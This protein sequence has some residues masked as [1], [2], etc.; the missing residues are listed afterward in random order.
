MEQYKRLL[1]YIKPYW[2]IAAIAT[3]FSFATSGISGAMVWYVKP[4]VDG[5]NIEKDVHIIK[6]FPLLYIVFF[7]LKGLFSFVHSFLMRAIGAKIVR[8]VREQL[9]SKLITLPMNFY[10]KKPSGELMSRI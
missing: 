6:T 1:S 5:I 3:V 2:W 8:D 4:V 9:F 7:L 10:I